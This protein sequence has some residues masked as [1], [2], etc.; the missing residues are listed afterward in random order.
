MKKFF[1]A[2][3][4]IIFTTGCFQTS[5][6]GF[7][8]AEVKNGT[9]FLVDAD[10][11]ETVIATSTNSQNID[12]IEDHLAQYMYT[13]A[14]LSPNKEFVALFAEGWETSYVRV[15]DIKTKSTYEAAAKELCPVTFKWTNDGLLQGAACGCA[16][17]F[18]PQQK[19]YKSIDAS[20]PWKIIENQTASSDHFIFEDESYMLT[21]PAEY[22]IEY[23]AEYGFINPKKPDSFPAI[24]LG[25]FG[26]QE[27]PG[28]ED[29]LEDEK[30]ILVNACVRNEGCG[31]RFET[32]GGYT[33][34]SSF[35]FEAEFSPQG[36]F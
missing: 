10:G 12:S 16:P 33:K 27:N 13:S 30:M 18:C 25:L 2:L 21:L 19:T 26:S 8:N 11:K 35:H 20:E 31:L 23:G 32:P 24:K 22:Q 28:V 6:T 5:G 4:V 29:I 9:V 34:N 3:I 15:Y 1:A 17:A 7:Q 14:A 36:I